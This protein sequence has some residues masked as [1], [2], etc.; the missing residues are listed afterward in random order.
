[1][2][3]FGKFMGCS[4]FPECRNAKPILKKIGVAC[5]ECGADIVER[6]TKQRRTFFGCSRYPE[7]SWTSWQRPVPEPCPKC[8]GLMVDMGKAGPRCTRCSAEEVAAAAP[9]TKTATRRA[10]AKTPAAAG[11]NG[12]KKSA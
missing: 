5:P 4:G 6:Q 9:S 10:P 1:M 2:G 8:G 12:R 11:R 3:R 7:C